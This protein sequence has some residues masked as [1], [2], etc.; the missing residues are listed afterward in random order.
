MFFQVQFLSFQLEEEAWNGNCD[1]DFVSV[2]Q[3]SRIDQSNLIK[4]IC[5][6]PDFDKKTRIP[7]KHNFISATGEMFVN[8]VSD[9][10]VIL[11]NFRLLVPIFRFCRLLSNSGVYLSINKINSNQLRVLNR[12]FMQ[13]IVRFQKMFQ[14]ELVMFYMQTLV[15][16]VQGF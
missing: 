1:F 5:G 4:T 14:L 11:H 10:T 2:Y 13:H 3:G 6:K 16:Q 9:N 12:D 7:Y 15:E 8:F